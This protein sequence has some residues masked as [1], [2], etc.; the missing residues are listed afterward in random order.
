MNAQNEPE[1]EIT[2]SVHHAVKSK[3]IKSSKFSI[4]YVRKNKK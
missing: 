4:S 3:T 1:V 2:R